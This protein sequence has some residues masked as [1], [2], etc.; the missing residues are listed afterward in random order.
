MSRGGVPVE[1]VLDKKKRMR[2]Q[3]MVLCDVSDSVR[4]A[5][6]FMLLF[7]YSL[8]ELFS[9]VRSFIFV[10]E[11]G[12][13]TNLFKDNDVNDAFEQTY[14]GGVINVFTHSNFGNAF[15]HFY[16]RFFPSVNSRTSVII[17]CDGRNNYNDPK[18]WVLGEI[19]RKA[20]KLI[21][22]N[23]ESKGSWGFGDSEMDKYSPHCNM[24]EEVKNLMDLE[25]VISKIVIQ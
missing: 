1:I 17:I 25:R 19:K 10:S 21:W 5:S 22:L 20:K 24:V 9:K 14:M 2:P 7:V 8:Q 3:L 23:P 11:L 13:V 12:E 18:D 15:S 16:E 4:H 6:R